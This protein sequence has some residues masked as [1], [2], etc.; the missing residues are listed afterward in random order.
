MAYKTVT[1]SSTG[2]LPCTQC[3]PADVILC[4]DPDKVEPSICP[5]SEYEP[6]QEP[7]TYRYIYG[8]IINW[9]RPESV[10]QC[11]SGIYS[12]VISYDD[13]QIREGETLET[14]DVTGVVCK[15]CLTTWIEDFVGNEP[16]LLPNEDG[17]YT[18]T[19]PH[20][21]QTTLPIGPAGE[22]SDGI[23]TTIDQTFSGDKTF[24]GDTA[25]EGDV[26]FFGSAPVS[27]PTVTGSVGGNTALQSL[28]DQLA[29]LGLI[30]DG[31]S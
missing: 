31:T 21:C 14:I 28:I 18:Y 9:Y 6:V 4:V 1:Y 25:F 11:P 16:T 13:A 29:A 10:L 5:G 12:Y 2:K 3:A 24:A 26:G 8:Q 27:Q 23:V 20:G 7:Y 19:T 15:G 17:T 30:I 22:D